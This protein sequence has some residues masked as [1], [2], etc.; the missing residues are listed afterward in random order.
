MVDIARPDLPIARRRRLLVLHSTLKAAPTLVIQTLLLLQARAGG[1][2]MVPGDATGIRMTRA[3]IS[4]PPL[5]AAGGRT[6]VP[7]DATGIRTTRVRINA[8]LV[9]GFPCLAPT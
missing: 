6:M 2:M 4:A 1:R 3:R 8:R 5:G 7:G 9:A